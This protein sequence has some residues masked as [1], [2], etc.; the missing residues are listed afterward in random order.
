MACGSG[1]SCYLAAPHTADLDS[2]AH[3]RI[4]L[5]P[6]N[7][8]FYSRCRGDLDFGLICRFL[9]LLI[10]GDRKVRSYPLCLASPIYWPMFYD[11]VSLHLLAVFLD[12]VF[13]HA[14]SGVCCHIYAI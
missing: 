9:L 10:S 5:I 3:L 8:L 12:H 7:L 13:C 2:V 6:A 4:Y 14:C 11:I 1:T